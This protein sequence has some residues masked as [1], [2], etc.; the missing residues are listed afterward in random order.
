MPVSLVNPTPPAHSIAAPL[1]FCA[2]TL[3]HH[4]AIAASLVKLSPFSFLR[5]ALYVNS[6]AV[7]ISVAAAAIWCCIAWNVPTGCPNCL[8]SYV[9][10]TARAN[11]PCARPIICAAMPTRP[12]FKI[13]IAIL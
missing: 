9:Y 1:T 5:A 12:S 10:G 2:T 11:A 7:S 3:A 13:S 4:L 6:R 8:R